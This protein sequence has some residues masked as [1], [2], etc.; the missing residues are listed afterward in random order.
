MSNKPKDKA[1]SKK[2]TEKQVNYLNMGYELDTKIEL[3]GLEFMELFQKAQTMANTL[4]K[5]VSVFTKSGEKLEGFTHLEPEAD[6][7]YRHISVM[8]R[9]FVDDGMATEMTELQKKWQAQYAS[10]GTENEEVMVE[11]GVTE[12]I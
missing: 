1:S 11:G 3:T 6:D 10:E 5:S 7:L 2:S 12:T 8:H 9:R 4:S